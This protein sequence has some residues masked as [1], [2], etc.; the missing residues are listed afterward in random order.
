MFIVVRQE[1]SCIKDLVEQFTFSLSS[2]IDSC[3]QNS[4]CDE[5]ILLHGWYPSPLEQNLFMG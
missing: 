4:M 3:V 2:L 1:E 5:C